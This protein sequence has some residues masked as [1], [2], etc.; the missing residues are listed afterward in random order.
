MPKL[1]RV[2]PLIS[3]LLPSLPIFLNW[4]IQ[5]CLVAK[6][7]PIPSALAEPLAFG[8]VTASTQPAQ[9]AQPEVVFIEGQAEERP[10]GNSVGLLKAAA[11]GSSQGPPAAL[12]ERSPQP[13]AEAHPQGNYYA[14]S[15]AVYIVGSNG[16]Q[17][18]AASP[19]YCPNQAPQSC[20]N[21]GVWNW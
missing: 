21:I 3:S 19:A 11:K 15:G 12:S 17:L 2:A 5:H 20:G 10:L 14:F 7:D 9:P 8:G 6:A 1:A 18:N 13:E 4:Q 16:Q